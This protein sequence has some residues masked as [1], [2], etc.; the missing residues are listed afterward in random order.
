MGGMSFVPSSCA[1]LRGASGYYAGAA[2]RCS[3]IAGQRIAPA[4]RHACYRPL[5]NAQP[6]SSSDKPREEG[7]GRAN[8]G[9]FGIR[10]EK[11]GDVLKFG[12]A[13]VAFAYAFKTGLTLAGMNDLF[14]GQV[15][16]GV[17]S[18]ASLLGWVST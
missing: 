4:S 9:L 17:V 5:M 7:D 15:T 3:R 11:N 6:P 16:T 1:V 13:F 12:I 18:I 10:I 8:R 2:H 14:A